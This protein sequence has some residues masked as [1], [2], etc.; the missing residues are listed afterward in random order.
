[1]LISLRSIHSG[2][3]PKKTDGAHIAKVPWGIV[4]I[5]L[6]LGG[7]G[8]LALYSA[9]G[10]D[11]NPWA[12]RHLV[13]LALG[14]TMMVITALI[15]IWLYRKSA[16]MCWL[17]VIMLLL[18][19]EVFGTGAGTQRWINIAGFNLQP[20]E[21]AK[22]GVIMLLASYFHTLTPEMTRSITTYIV[23]AVIPAVPM[24]LIA[25]QPDLG[26]AIML[27]AIAS[28]LIFVAG[29]P[30]WMIF[31]SIALVFTAIPFAWTQLYSYQK[32]RILVFLNPF[33]EQLG[34][35]YQITQSKI[36]LGSGGLLGK[37]YLQGS[38][39]KLN[40]LPE[41]QTDFVF[42]MIGE[43]FG[44]LGCAFTLLLYLVLI[45]LILRVG[46]RLNYLFGRLVSI[47]VAAIISLY[48]FVNIGMVSGILPVVGAPLPFVSY[49]GTA[50]ITLFVAL[51]LIISA[52]I[53]DD[54]CID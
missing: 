15:P 36:A 29:I 40:Y 39:S 42:S 31:T 41:K 1:M 16:T 33:S 23:A 49:G 24:A 52:S 10:G 25:V 26:T 35:G 9:A 14:V 37:G 11:W 38:Q 2:F 19:V 21:L 28:I 54:A 46:L 4:T 17:A 27:F 50:L 8:V 53:Y 18:A 12:S 51:G 45:L 13:R 32:E 43:E 5:A 3:E 6:I 44:F 22:L 34:A 20:S 30:R 7:I 48:V 47:G